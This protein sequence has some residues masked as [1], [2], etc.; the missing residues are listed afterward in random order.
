MDCPPTGD[1]L[2]LL[3]YW[4]GKRFAQIFD[5]V[6]NIYNGS[7]VNMNTNDSWDPEVPTQNCNTNCLSSAEINITIN[8][9]GCT[10]SIQ[11]L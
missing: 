11:Q 4:P 9:C 1:E 6:N 10:D 8:N 3:G 2:G 7:F 5:V